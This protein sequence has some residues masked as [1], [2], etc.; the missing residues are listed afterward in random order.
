MELRTPISA[1]YRVIGSASPHI[2]LDIVVHARTALDDADVVLGPADDC[3]YYLIAMHN[4]YDV[5]SGIPMSTGVVIQMTIKLAEHQGLKV[6]LLK[7][8]FDVDE[9][10]DLLHLG[11]LL[12]ADTS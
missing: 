8:L 12:R 3:G 10:P 2:S 9:L 6:H 1:H 5:F 11:W 4:P 7:P